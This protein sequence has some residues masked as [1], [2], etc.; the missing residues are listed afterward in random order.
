MCLLGFSSGLPFLLVSYTLS[1]WLKQNGWNVITAEL[2]SQILRLVEV[3]RAMVYFIRFSVDHIQRINS[4]PVGI[5]IDNRLAIHWD[6]A[7]HTIR[8]GDL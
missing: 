6:R 8:W 5:G 7:F 4:S 1:F 2:H 3:H